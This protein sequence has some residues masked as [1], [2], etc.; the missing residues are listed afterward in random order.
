MTTLREQLQRDEGFRPDPYPDFVGDADRERI[1]ALWQTFLAAGG[2]VAVG[3]GRN[4]STNPL[5]R[6]E[7]GYLLDTDLR[8]IETEV[9]GALPW[10]N[11][12]DAPRRAVL[13]NMAYNL[14]LTGLLGFRRMLEA[15]KKGDWPTAGNEMLDSRWARQV[16]ERATRLVRQMVSGTW[17]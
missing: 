5:T 17:Q 15:A 14:G 4:L 10:I 8:R 13:F 9:L 16:S 11:G 7:A 2:T 12:L 6:E 1:K 3:Y